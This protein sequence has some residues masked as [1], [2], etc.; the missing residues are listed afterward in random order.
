ML[1]PPTPSAG[2]EGQ[3]QDDNPEYYPYL[4]KEN[5]DKQSK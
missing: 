3:S 1:K 2:H 4:G 5:D